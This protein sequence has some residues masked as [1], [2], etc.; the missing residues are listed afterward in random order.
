MKDDTKGYSMPTDIDYSQ[1]TA[2][3]RDTARA[4]FNRATSTGYV[5]GFSWSDR[6][7]HWAIRIPLAG[8]LMYYGLQ[9]FPGALVAP[10]DYGVPAV[11]YILAAFA[12]VLGA[13]ALILGGIF[14]TWRPALGELRL[15]GDVL[16]RGGGF[17]GVAAVLGVIAFFYW[18]A[19]TIAD[20]QVMALGLSAFFL[21]RGNNYGSRPAAAYG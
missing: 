8:L 13:V 6:F 15:I 16:T 14:E 2:R 17:A 11:L 12:E 10:G 3:L 20:L 4:M 19:L 1:N 21:L 18:G 5:P 7:A 9:K